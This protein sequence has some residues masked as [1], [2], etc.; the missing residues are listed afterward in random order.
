M[1]R[2]MLLLVC[3]SII[4]LSFAQTRQL[5]GKV[6][7]ETGAPLVGASILI[8]NTKLGSQTDAAGKFL[9]KTSS[10]GKV[11]L[12]ISYTGYKSAIITV[13]KEE[14]VIA[15][16]E[17]VEVAMDDIVVIGYSS[18]KRKDLTG[19]VSSVSNKQFKDVPVSSAAAAH[20]AWSANIFTTVSDM[21]PKR[22]V[23]S[24]T[25]IGGMFGAFG[26][27]FLSLFVQKNLFVHYRSINQI[28]TAYYV[29]FFVCG[30][31]YITAWLVLHILVP[32]MQVIKDE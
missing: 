23:G 30:L 6:V 24:V 21:F 7:D 20:Q 19:S 29:M 2:L 4:V 11:T 16:L 14:E 28:E 8:R 1:K 3:M 12:L 9:I 17:K 31:A 32:R 25:G 26:G 5:R 15:K 27:I 10:T 13:D 18:V 22:A